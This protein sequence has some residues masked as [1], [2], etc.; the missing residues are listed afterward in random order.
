MLH[1][2]N[3]LYVTQHSL[4]R[5]IND[6]AQFNNKKYRTELKE[7]SPLLNSTFCSFRGHVL[8]PT[9]RGSQ[10]PI[11][12][13][14]GESTHLLAMRETETQKQKYK[15]T[16]RNDRETAKERQRQRDTH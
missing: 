2:E 11:T 6:S 13:T 5:Q 4:A 7:R 12:L 8:L 16:Q 1:R 10:P 14:P 3:I 9:S 15:E